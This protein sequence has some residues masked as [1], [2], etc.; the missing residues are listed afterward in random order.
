MLLY[1][2]CTLL[3][4]E[5]EDVVA[6]F[7]AAHPEF[8]REGFTLPGPVGAVPEGEITLWPQRTGTDGF[9]LAR[10]RRKEATP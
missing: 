3:R 5:D 1:S 9:Y 10:L 2:T 7:L 6:G 4:A 8:V